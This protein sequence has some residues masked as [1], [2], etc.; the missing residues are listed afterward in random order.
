MPALF[1][2][3]FVLGSSATAAEPPA[4]DRPAKADAPK[5]ADY[6]AWAASP[7]GKAEIARLTAPGTR[8]QFRLVSVDPADMDVDEMADDLFTHRVARAVS[9]NGLA[10]AKAAATTDVQSGHPLVTI[11]LTEAGGRIMERL[12]AA[13]VDRRLA[14]VFDGKLV[15]APTIRSAIGRRVVIT[16]GKGGGADE[17]RR[18][19]DA[20]SPPAKRD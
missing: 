4:P 16:V 6:D 5:P 7:E 20:I 12:T 11:E 3:A 2:L 8:L 10:V 19:A 17:A 1:V 15:T 14:I 18:I 9:L 13:N